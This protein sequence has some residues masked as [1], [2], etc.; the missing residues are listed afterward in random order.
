MRKTILFLILYLLACF[1]LQ[2][3]LVAQEEVYTITAKELER[4]EIISE[5]WKTQKQ[6]LLKE[7]KILTGK[8]EEALKTS[9]DLKNLLKQEMEISKSLRQSFDVY[10]SEVQNEINALTFEIHQK[11]LVIEKQK[12]RILLLMCIS[13]F[14]VLVSITFFFLKAKLKIF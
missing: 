2:P 6:N 7:T 14:I 8:L 1:Y 4:L 12:R 3:H 9:G 10:E 11:E 13:V 5:N